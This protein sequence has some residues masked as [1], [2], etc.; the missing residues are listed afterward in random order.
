MDTMAFWP[1]PAPRCR[2]P[3]QKPPRRPSARA[4]SQP[5]ASLPPCVLLEVPS[6]NDPKRPRAH[7]LIVGAAARSCTIQKLAALNSEK[8]MAITLRQ[9][10]YF[11]AVAETGKMALA[12]SN[13]GVS[14]SSITEAV[15]ALEDGFG[16]PLLR[17]HR[18]GVSLTNE[19]Y[20]FL[21]H[22]RNVTSA[23]ADASHG[24]QRSRTRVSG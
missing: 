6:L 2:S 17:R 21:R 10:R 8:P 20:Q 4:L 18:A 12:A 23:V 13:I 22:A 9:I 15:K 24:V 19:G 7:A 11:L 14:Q 16:V 1:D 5:S 3:R